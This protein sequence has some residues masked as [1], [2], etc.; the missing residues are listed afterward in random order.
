MDLGLAGRT[1]V[2]TGSS[3]GLGRGLVLAFAAEG[4]N[5][6]LAD[7]DTEQGERIAALV[8]E[9]DTEALVLDT[10]VTSPQ[11]VHSLLDESTA[12][13]GAVDVLVNNAGGAGRPRPFLEKDP[14]ELRSEID[15]NVWGVVH[16]TRAIGAHMIDRGRGAIVNIASNAAVLGAAAQYVENYAGSKGYVTALSR[17]LADAWGPLGVRINCIAPGWIVPHDEE[18]VGSRSFWPRFGYE[19]FGSLASLEEQAKTGALPAVESQPLRKLGRPE[20]IANLAL[21]LASDVAGHLTG[22]LI[23]VSGGAYMP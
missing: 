18:H 21:F 13:F 19:A 3:G 4:C 1:A 7:P 14:D 10:D 8:R 9:G 5:V 6:V 16:C 2:V 22:Q 23:S 12:R 20:D 17:A 11:A 15:L